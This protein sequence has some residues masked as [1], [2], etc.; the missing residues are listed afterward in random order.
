MS[1]SLLQS[2]SSEE[3]EE[4][5]EEL[6]Y[7]NSD[8]GGGGDDLRND[9]V[10]SNR[11]KPLFDPNPSS[12]SSLPSALDAFSEVSIII[13]HISNTIIAEQRAYFNFSLS[14]FFGFLNWRFRGHRNF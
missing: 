3:E 12:C 8:D 9:S 7:D 13:K 4:K 10:S 5:R 1:L 14:F 11:Y 6:D 2:Y